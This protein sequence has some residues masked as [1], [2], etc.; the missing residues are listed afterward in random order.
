MVRRHSP[1]ADVLSRRAAPLTPIPRCVP[2]IVLFIGLE[3]IAVCD[4]AASS[5]AAAGG[6]VLNASKASNTAQVSAAPTRDLAA[7]P[8]RSPVKRKPLL[9]PR[10]GE[11]LGTGRSRKESLG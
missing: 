4:H 7:F 3:G 1:L 11:S 5:Q 10:R 2:D 6:S 9:A 8:P